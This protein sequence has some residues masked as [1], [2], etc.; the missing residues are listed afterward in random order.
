MNYTAPKEFGLFSL[1]IALHTWIFTISDSFALQSLIQFG[2]NKESK[3]QVNLISLII[4]VSLTM[5]V[6][7]L[8]YIFRDGLALLFHEDRIKEIGAFLPMLSLAFIPRSYCQK[9]IYRIQNMKFL[10]FVNLLF[11]GT[12]SL[13]I[14]YRIS[15]FHV[16]QFSD[17]SIFYLVGSGL[18]SLFAIYLIRKELKFEKFNLN[19]VKEITKFGIPMT[20]TNVLHSMPKQLDIFT[21]KYFFSLEIVGLYSAAKNIYRVF[22][23]IINAMN[24]LIYPSAVKQVTNNNQK[25]LSDLLTKSVSFIFILFSLSVI[26]LLLGGSSIIFHAILPSKYIMSLNYFNYMILGVPFMAFISI[27][28]IL[29]AKNELKTIINF[30][31]ISNIFFFS[32]IIIFG[33]LGSSNYLA[34]SL[35]I[36]YFV[37]GILA[38]IYSTLKMNFKFLDLFRSIKDSYH[39]IKIIGSKNEKIS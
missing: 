11:F 33:V 6:S 3:N 30:V 25:A 35:S 32:T 37:L 14:L 20:I 5:T 18:S 4:H 13:L 16:L 7:L 12:I 8:I 15:Q 28:S 31:T 29:T 21:I 10:F 17:L 24:G 26:I 19:N 2:M 36:Y 22:D 27:Y 38:F 23:E 9:I 34:L 1:L 39:F